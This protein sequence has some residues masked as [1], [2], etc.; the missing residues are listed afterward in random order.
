[1]ARARALP[2]ELTRVHPGSGTPT[3]AILVQTVINILLGLVLP[4]AIGVANVYNV[5]GTW[6]TFALAFVYVVSNYGLFVFYR[7][8]HRDEFSWVKHASSRPSGS[9][10]GRRGLLLG[11]SAARLAG[12]AGAVHRGRLA[13]GRGDRAR[14]RLPRRPPRNLALA[15]AAMGESVEAAILERY[16]VTGSVPPP[17]A[18]R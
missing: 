18:E 16:S 6:F 1:M 4:L 10:A 7:R 3:N 2:S 15:G 17:D 14:R 11:Q 5:T 13:G 9:G 8:E 12:L